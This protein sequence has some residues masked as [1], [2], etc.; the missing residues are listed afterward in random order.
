MNTF[1]SKNNREYTRE[2]GVFDNKLKS[3]YDDTLSFANISKPNG[4]T[5]V[6][7]SKGNQRILCAILETEEVFIIRDMGMEFGLFIPLNELH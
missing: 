3:F 1:T 7:F 2:D 5:I 6:S 4:N